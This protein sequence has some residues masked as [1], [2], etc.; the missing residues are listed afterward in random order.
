[1][2][3]SPALKLPLRKESTPGIRIGTQ[4]DEPDLD[5]DSADELP[6]SS[7]RN[8][9]ANMEMEEINLE[10]ERNEARIVEMPF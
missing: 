8:D 2:I 3:Q 7:N 9:P 1:M 10:Q 4:S 5:L 6:L